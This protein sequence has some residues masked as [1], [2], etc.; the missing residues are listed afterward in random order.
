MSVE[1][2]T[3]AS[4]ASTDGVHSIDTP[5]GR[6]MLCPKHAAQYWPKAPELD[7]EP[8]RNGTKPKPKSKDKATP[9]PTGDQST[10]AAWLT[11]VDALAVVHDPVSHALRFGNGLDAVVR[12]YL[13]SGCCIRF[14]PARDAFDPSRLTITVSMAVPESTIKRPTAARAL[15]VG[16]AIMRLAE[17]QWQDDEQAESETWALR[18]LPHVKPLGYD[19]T[20]NRFDGIYALQHHRMDDPD[21]WEH[22]SPAER[23]A[24]L[25]DTA[26]GARYVRVSDFHEH[27]RVTCGTPIT[28]ARLRGRMG[29]AGWRAVR[30]QAWSGRQGSDGGR[31]QHANVQAFEVPRD[32]KENH[33]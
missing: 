3:C 8:R 14:E 25:V 31:G 7:A 9:P 13:R 33:R 28:W 30:L 26:T 29:E 32:Q 2:V 15:L 6:Q 4:C 19:L 24:M 12:V 20:V 27:V 21:E 10:I 5:G 22:A 16:Q 23:S 1:I 17:L 18:F 11:D